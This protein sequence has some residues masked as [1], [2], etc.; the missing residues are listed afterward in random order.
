M[1]SPLKNSPINREFIDVIIVVRRVDM[2]EVLLSFSEREIML[3]MMS[4][5]EER[6]IAIASLYSFV[7]LSSDSRFSDIANVFLLFSLDCFTTF[8]IRNLSCRNEFSIN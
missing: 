4:F 1:G 6:D 2:D 3:G 8:A 7:F 5:K